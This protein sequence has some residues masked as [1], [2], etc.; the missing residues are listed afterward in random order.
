VRL[1]ALL[2]AL[3]VAG[4]VSARDA[5]VD[6]MLQCQGCHGADGRGAPGSVP[7]L[8]GQVARFALV[9][10]GR[11]YLVR[12]PGSAGS[13]LGDAALAEVLN[14]MVRRF[15]PADAAAAFAPYSADEVAPLRRS[16]LLDVQSVRRDLLRQLGS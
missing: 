9:P 15:G 8:R 4:P 2:L 1:A 6:W 7:D 11:E 12:V 14:W 5:Q 3:L 10:G 13:P 16:P